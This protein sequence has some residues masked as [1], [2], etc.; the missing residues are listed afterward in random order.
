MFTPLLSA[1]TEESPC[2]PSCP[3]SPEPL[4]ARAGRGDAD[5]GLAHPGRRAARGMSLLEIMVVITLIGLVTA[6]VG[7]SVMGTLDDGQKKLAR[8]QAFQLEEAV[9]GYRLKTGR[10][11]MAA[12]GLAALTQPTPRAGRPSLIACPQ[13]LGA[14][15]M[16]MSGRARRTRRPSTSSAPGPTAR[17]APTTT[18]ATG[19][20]A[21]ERCA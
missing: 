4:S 11:P 20:R 12:E 6:A 16:S 2:C 9:N 13:I 19:R 1:T 18:S 7:V 3:L 5:G 8:D 15:G 10:L 17:P 21:P 14:G